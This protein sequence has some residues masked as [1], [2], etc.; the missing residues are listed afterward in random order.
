MSNES[1]LRERDRRYVWHPW[2][3]VTADR[4]QLMIA[5]GT[6]H[7]VEDIG[8]TEYIDASSLNSTCGYGHP[9][10]VDAVRR[11]LARLH[12][13]D[14]SVASH[15]VAGLLAERLAAYLPPAL[16]RTLF[17]NSGSEGIEAAVLIAHS[18]F[19]QR[20]RPRSRVV[21]LAA[22]YH[23]STMLARSLSGL[24]RV[25]H[26][27]QVPL[28]VT[29]VPLPAAPKDMR[30]PAALSALLAALREAVE[31]DDPP[32]AVVVEP[33]LNVGGGIV[34]PEGFL[35]GVRELCDASGALLVLDEVFTAYGRAGRM[36]AFQR[37]GAEPD[38]LV[39]SKGLGGGYLP[40][41][42]VTVRD[43][44]FDS[45]VD[46]PVIGGLRYGHTTSGHAAACAAALATLDVLDKGDLLTRADQF[47]ARMLDRFGPSAGSGDVVD[48]RGLGMIAVF[49]FASVAACE[50]VLGRARAEG[51]LLRQHGPV[52]MAVPPLTIDDDG[53]SA[54]ADRLDRALEA[55][56]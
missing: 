15:E 36:F 18:Y 47:C 5:R 54:L 3:P 22:G 25:E 42:A 50:R 4:T 9:E 34:L 37:E 21:T 13:L 32:M 53:V 14:I 20:G 28:P 43:H 23:G 24:P 7:H 56:R 33:F 6:G 27:F 55:V 45:F 30:T 12:G 38:V 2:S 48:V 39:T 51:L 19:S 17:V 41:A 49:E 44:V 1:L 31:G 29:R 16:H 35:R 40:I 26:P 8:G 52:A 11:Q 10:L 46:E